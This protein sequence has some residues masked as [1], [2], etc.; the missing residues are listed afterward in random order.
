MSL[1]VIIVGAGE[2]GY[3]IAG[4][5]AHEYKDVVVVD[6]N[7][8]A[9]RRVSENIDAN[10]IQGAGSS[11][12]VLEEAGLKEAE[13]FLAVTDSDEINLAACLVANAMSPTTKKLARI[14]SA[15]YDHYHDIFREQAPHIDTV[16][17]PEIEVVKSIERLMELPGIVGVGEFA[18][19][20]VKIIGTVLVEGSQLSGAC[21]KDLPEKLGTSALL[22]AA[23]VR[24]DEL[25]VPTGED[26]MLPDDIVYFICEAE[27]QKEALAIFGKQLCPV[28]RAMIIGGGRIGTRLAHRLEKRSISTKLIEKD[29]IRCREL[30][31]SMNKVVVL[32]GDGSDLGMLS[33]EN[34]R[35][36]D[37]VITLTNDEETNILVSL[38]AKR[39][40]ARN[41]ITKITKF[42][43]FSLI[44]TIGLQQVVSPRLSA[45]DTILQHIRKGK[46]LSAWSINGEQSE[47]L[48]AVALQTSDIVG[49]P[50]R[51]LSFPKRALVISVI[52]DDTI[53]IPSGDTVVEVG[54]RIII[55]AQRRAIPKIEKFLSVKL[56]YI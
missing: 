46:V 9:L 48:E 31:E 22:V 38:L 8:A 13:I 24:D 30:A 19:G 26:C 20:R 50:L 10:V 5:L 7:A 25:I 42:G 54:D 37:V 28:Q 35:G 27:K 6:C 14:R 41:T 15:D 43:Y 52:R 16:I 40:G 17:N 18:D 56:E 3:H 12:L 4:R 39:M 32:H 29:P 49:K 11:P 51:K 55:F 44:S 1:K 21:L 34:I 36:M 33:E 2:V 45:I 53:I 23:I 47:V